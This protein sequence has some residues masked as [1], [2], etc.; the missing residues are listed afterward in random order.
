[1][2]ILVREYKQEDLQDAVKI[3]NTVIEDG[4]AFPQ[5]N[6]LTIENGNEF[7]LSQSFTGIAIDEE[8]REVVGLYTLHP[9]NVG[10]CGHLSN[11][12]YAVKKTIRGQK[13]GEHLVAH[14]LKKAKE[15]GFHIMQFNAVVATN[16]PAL[17]LYKKLG[18]IQ[19]GTIPKGFLMKDGH[20]ED[21]VLHYIEL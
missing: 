5:L 12:S 14:S 16:H 8:S 15:L 2:K 3:W 13:V 17:H 4:I 7:F 9:N 10:R 6:F 20:Y 18:F 11:T 1:M 19:L 21:I